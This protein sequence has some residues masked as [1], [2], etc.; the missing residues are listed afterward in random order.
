MTLGDPIDLE[1]PAVTREP[2]CARVSGFSAHANVC[3]PAR[4]RRQ[5]EK[6]FRYTARPPVA[7]ERLS[8]LVMF[9]VQSKTWWSPGRM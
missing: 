2:R 7:T 6:L 3:I 4:A 9:R 5:L 1:T 8:K